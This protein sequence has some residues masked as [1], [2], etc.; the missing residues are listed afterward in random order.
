MPTVKPI[1]LA[2]FGLAFFAGVSH[3]SAMDTSSGIAI[4]S[5][6]SGE[7]KDG[8]VICSVNQKNELCTLAYDPNMLGVVSLNPAISVGV[9]T[10]SA[11]TPPVVSTG[12]AKVLVS[13][14]NGVVEKGDFVTSSTEPGVATKMLKSGYSLGIALEPFTPNVSEHL[15][16]ITVSLN[17]RPTV[18]TAKANVNL[19]EMVRQ[20]LE[21]SFLT[22]LSS[23]RYLVAGI[24]VIMTFVYGFSHFGKLAKSGVEAVGR[25]PLAS[26][27]I[28]LSVML[29]VGLTVLIM[30]GGVLIGYLILSL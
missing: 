15:G 20:G 23:L 11:D 17:I 30:G 12:K 10:P 14:V 16:Y 3:V 21:S 29:N 28:E 18:L 2:I 26:R 19:I 22:P 6:V 13:D 5:I 27:A 4:F 9:A 7:V 24:V 1:R 25:N 8:T